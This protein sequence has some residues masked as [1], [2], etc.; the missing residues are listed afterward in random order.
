MFGFLIIRK[1]FWVCST[2]SVKPCSYF[3]LTSFKL[4]DE[5]LLNLT[6]FIE[7]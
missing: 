2:Y 1:I 5:T 7:I 4:F 6:D 3:K